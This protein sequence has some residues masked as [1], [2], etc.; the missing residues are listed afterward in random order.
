MRRKLFSIA[1][2]LSSVSSWRVGAGRIHFLTCQSAPLIFSLACVQSTRTLSL[3][4]ETISCQ[5]YEFASR[6]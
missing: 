4:L 6:L 1:W 2:H 5:A 3:R